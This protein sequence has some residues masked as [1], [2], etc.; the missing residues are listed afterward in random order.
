MIRVTGVVKR[1]W[2]LLAVVAVTVVAGST[3]Y[4]LHRIFGVHEQPVVKVK[5]DDDA[6]QFNPK[7][8][9][10][11]VFGPARTARITYLDPDAK[12]QKLENIPLPWSETVSTTLPSVSVNLFAQSNSDM[13]GCRILVNGTV[14]DEQSETGLKALTVCQ[15][16]AA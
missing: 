3:I 8:V 15:V 7:R 4:R 5:A 6:P 2:L 10:Y 11:E 1:T 16:S 9:T 13:I 12:V 14:K